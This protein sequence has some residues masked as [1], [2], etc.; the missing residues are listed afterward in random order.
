MLEGKFICFYMILWGL[1]STQ[2]SAVDFSEM[3]QTLL[4]ASFNN[5]LSWLAKYK[6]RGI[7]AIGVIH[8][9]VQVVVVS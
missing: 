9:A 8:A 3:A 5:D 6:C 1:S 2:K 7:I 4:V